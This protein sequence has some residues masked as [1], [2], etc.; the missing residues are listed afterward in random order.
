MYKHKN[1]GTDYKASHATNVKTEKAIQAGM[2]G[3]LF[4]YFTL[5]IDFIN[6]AIDCKIVRPDCT[7]RAYRTI[8]H[9]ETRIQELCQ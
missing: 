1:V 4:D 9:F 7:A 8:Q 2:E 3:R 6:Y 5:Q